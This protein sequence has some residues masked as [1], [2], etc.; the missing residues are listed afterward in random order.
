MFVLL[1]YFYQGVVV[2]MDVM[3]DKVLVSCTFKASLFKCEIMPQGI[4]DANK[5]KKVAH[6][7]KVSCS[8]LDLLLV[9]LLEYIVIW[10]YTFITLT[11]FILG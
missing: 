3:W 11:G 5:N 4:H 7:C 8:V 10:S 6:T 9:L 1:V 2:E